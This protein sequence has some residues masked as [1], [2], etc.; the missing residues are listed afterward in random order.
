[1]A[2]LTRLLEGAKRFLYLPVKDFL[3][4]FLVKIKNAVMLACLGAF[5]MLTSSSSIRILRSQGKFPLPRS[6]SQWVQSQRVQKPT[7]QLKQIEGDIAQK[8]L[9]SIRSWR[10]YNEAQRRILYG[11]HLLLLDQAANRSLSDRVCLNRFLEEEEWVKRICYE[12]FC[13]FATQLETLDERAFLL[14]GDKNM[15]PLNPNG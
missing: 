1:M 3:T 9:E 5:V 10:S 14:S 4:A 7:D 11:T 12:S 15:G 6:T 13:M 8:R 2:F